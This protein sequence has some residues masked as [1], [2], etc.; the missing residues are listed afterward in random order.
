MINRTVPDWS[1]S[2]PDHGYRLTSFYQQM[3]KAQFSPLEPVMTGVGKARDFT[4]TVST[5]E[6]VYQEIIKAYDRM[7]QAFSRASQMGAF[8]GFFSVITVA[9]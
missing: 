5:V 3:L 4:N 7:K 2:V 1:R 9:W 8:V 6:A